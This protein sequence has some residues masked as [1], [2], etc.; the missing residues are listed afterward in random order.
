MVVQWEPFYWHGVAWARAVP[1]GRGVRF[2]SS[3]AQYRL[4]A[5]CV[6]AVPLSCVELVIPVVRY[7]WFLDHGGAGPPSFGVC[8][9]SSCE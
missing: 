4:F 8:S 2:V 9:I 1:L 5:A 7:E 6:G 3:T